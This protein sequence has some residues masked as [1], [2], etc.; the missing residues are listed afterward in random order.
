MPYTFCNLSNNRLWFARSK[1]LRK[2]TNTVRTDPP[3]SRQ[4]IQECISAIIAW[5]V[6]LPPR[7]PNWLLSKWGSRKG[8]SHLPTIFSRT[9]ASV[10][11]SEI[12][13][14][15]FCIDIGGLTLDTGM[16]SAVSSQLKHVSTIGKNLLNSN[17]SSRRPRN[18]ANFGPLTA[19]I[20]LPVWGTPANFSRFRVLASLL[21]RRRK[22][23]ANQTLHD[24]WLSP[25]LVHY[26][27]CLKKRPTFGLL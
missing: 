4:D 1:A 2:S 15:S 13:L 7:E 12:G 20:G 14:K 22:P 3:L 26:T 6:D 24:L 25:G 23:E 21:Q 17:I 11:N 16:T 5:V 9:L 27:P 8:R 10:G 18:M 19:E